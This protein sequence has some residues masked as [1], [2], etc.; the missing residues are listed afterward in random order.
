[1]FILMSVWYRDAVVKLYGALASLWIFD[2]IP[3]YSHHSLLTIR[4]RKKNF[5]KVPSDRFLSFK[6]EM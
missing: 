6:D 2:L 4:E 1:M 5:E 3:T